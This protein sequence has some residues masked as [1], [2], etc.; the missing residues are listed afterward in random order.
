VVTK[1]SPWSVADTV[2]PLLAVAAA[3]DL[4]VFAVID[5]SA[6]ATSVGLL[7]RETKLVSLSTELEARLAG[8]DGLTSAVIAR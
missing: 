5:H 8:I 1:L 6:E 2:T 4:K 3:R 7:L